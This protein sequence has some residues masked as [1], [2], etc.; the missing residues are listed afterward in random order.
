MGQVAS[1]VGIGVE[2]IARELVAIAT[3]FHALVPGAFIGS[4]TMR[5]AED[6]LLQRYLAIMVATSTAKHYFHR[7]VVFLSQFLHHA[8]CLMVLMGQEK[9]TI[10]A[11]QTTGSGHLK[12]IHY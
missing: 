7:Y 9:V 1:F 11:V 4:T 12:I 10:E 5:F 8:H 6:M 3:K 2:V